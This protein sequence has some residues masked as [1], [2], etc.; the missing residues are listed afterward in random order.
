MQPTLLILAAGI[1]SRYG[2]LKQLETVGPSGE[3]I[4]DYSIYDA[5][6]ADFGKAVF[7]IRPDMEAAFRELIGRRYERR[8]AV[9]YAFQ[10]LDGLP[11]GFKP[12]AARAKPWGTGH[13]VLAARDAIREPFAVINADDFYGANS[14]AALGRFLR[15][16]KSGDVPTYAMVGFTLRETLSEA[17]TVNRGCCE[18]T[19]DGYLERITEITGL[20]RYGPDARYTDE[21]GRERILSGDTPVSMNTWGFQPILF[22]QLGERFEDFLR[23]HAASETAE[24]HLPTGVQELVQA[25]RARVKVLPTTDTWVG[26]THPE[27]KPRVVRTINKLVE[28]GTYPR[29][30]WE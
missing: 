23:R 25:G 17:G 15:Q 29:Q 26:V 16:D 27:D 21:H 6:R 1:G 2:G 30:L 20:A 28:Q 3:T 4:M 24:F 7:V 11:P 10:R 18:R 8:I 14:L 19:A 13:A 12:P 9:A 22:E 5:L